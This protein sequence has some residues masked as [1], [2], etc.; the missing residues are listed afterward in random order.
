MT[1]TSR[2]CPRATYRLQLH[3]GFGFADAGAIAPYLADLGVSHVYLSPVFAARP[4]STHGY[5]G[6]DHN[7][8]NPELGGAEGFRTMADAF[9]A[10]GLGL[11]LDFV[12][13]HMG[14]GGSTNAFWLSVLEW[15]PESPHASR[16]DIDWRSGHPGLSGHVLMPFLGDS[17]GNLL[18]TE[19]LRLAYDDD[20][21]FIL[22]H[23]T[24]RLPICPR[25]YPAILGCAP[26]LA[27]QANA[28]AAAGDTPGADAVWGRLKAGLAAAR[29]DDPET[30]AGI[31]T[32]L[33]AHNGDAARLGT[34]ADAQFWRA[35][36][37]TL[38]NDAINYRR[39]FTISDLAGLRVEDPKIF[40]ETHRLVLA[41]L[42]DGTI[43]GIRIDH[44]DGLA[45]PK[46]Y[47]TRL[48]ARAARPFWLLVE[49]IL[50]PD[51]TLPESW[52]TDGTTGYEVTNLLA[53][54]LINPDSGPEL[55]RLWREVTGRREKAHD[56]VLDGK[57][58]IL[59]GPMAAECEALTSRLHTLARG[60]RRT[61]DLGRSA[62][63]AGLIEVI[64]AFG[65]YRTY[66]DA[67]GLPAEDCPRIEAAMAAART[68]LPGIESG[69]FEFLRSVLTLDLAR[70][71][72]DA[73][74]A[75]HAAATC[76]QQLSGPVMAKGLEDTALY[77]WN[78]MIA[79]NE[80]GSEPG[81]A[82]VT[83]E[84]FHAANTARQLREPRAMLTTS[85]HDTKR[86][87]DARMRIAALT[88]HLPEWEKS[89]AHWRGLVAD[90][91]RPVDPN[92]EYFFYQL[93]LGAWPF[94]W[95]DLPAA[96]ALEAF[97]I[98]VTEAMLK[99]A[100]E[101]GANTRWVQGDPAYEDALSAL[102][103]R[104]LERDGAFL[105]AFRTFEARIAPDALRLSLAQTALKLTAPGVPD[106]YQGAELWEQSLVDP[107]NRRPVDFALR[108]EH[109]ATA[110]PDTVRAAAASWDGRE[111]LAL[112]ASLLRFR[113]ARPRL[114]AEGT[115]EPIETGCGR[116]I[117]FRRATPETELVVGVALPPE[118]R[119]PG[120]ALAAVACSPGWTDVLT[121]ADLSR[122]EIR[123]VF[124]ERPIA[125][126]VSRRP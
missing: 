7:L 63:R 37:F 100:R 20:G 106:I 8:L 29:A 56:I 50:A 125:I 119:G 96:E 42:A 62:L 53:G 66:A 47:T 57:R 122:E 109:L 34:L 27:A 10:E 90:R 49:K 64:A 86:G 74:R 17:L 82:P 91:E 95:R 25:C 11:L 123:E 77:R 32:A 111:K 2:P 114:F 78:P 19:A 81:S 18:G 99:S 23:D 68:S 93:L 107:D 73:E 54:L 83:P 21:F 113:R 103:A 58:A 112:T 115:Y 71:R 116:I 22:A 15:G 108:T 12:P 33:A 118:T 24:H 16:F 60:D 124:A 61:A 43:D 89:V 88:F 36:K 101:A 75:I 87:E 94:E 28:F 92:E 1:E 59:E 69:V 121:G 55:V 105:S 9:R 79:L 44:I 4:G 46:G 85:T 40:E 31:E 84:A 98:R 5:D 13:N 30:R 51:E 41:L 110:R 76:F 35:A 52:Q 65:V 26:R 67:D 104:A 117:A 97:R 120:A 38:A 126:L 14:I 48:R 102:V 45:D 39:F 3:G 6:I 80:V 72:P 70:A